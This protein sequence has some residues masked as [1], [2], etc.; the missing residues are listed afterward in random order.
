M[1][2]KNESPAGANGR[3][4]NLDTKRSADRQKYSAIHYAKAIEGVA[5][6]VVSFGDFFTPE[7]RARA[8]RIGSISALGSV[9]VSGDIAFLG[10]AYSR[11][12]RIGGVE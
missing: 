5:V 1:T 4:S 6:E 9:P 7:E 8:F 12:L 3:A 11:M 10:N 2:M